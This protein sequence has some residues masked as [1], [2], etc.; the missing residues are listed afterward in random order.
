[1]RCESTDGQERARVLFQ[2]CSRYLEYLAHELGRAIAEDADARSILCAGGSYILTTADIQV[3][4]PC[5]YAD[6][7]AGARLAQQ[8]GGDTDF[9]R[10][11]ANRSELKLSRPMSIACDQH[12][13]ATAEVEI[14]RLAGD[15]AAWKRECGRYVKSGKVSLD[16]I[17]RDPKVGICADAQDARPY[18]AEKAAGEAKGLVCRI[19]LLGVQCQTP[20]ERHAEMADKAHVISDESPVAH[21]HAAAI[22]AQAKARRSAPGAQPSL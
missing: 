20:A 16:L 21:A 1:R 8:L 3:P 15:S 12:S 13:D 7:I 17:M 18:L 14:Q 5:E 11:C 9:E 2:A 4:E 19:T 22:I 10:Q 6:E